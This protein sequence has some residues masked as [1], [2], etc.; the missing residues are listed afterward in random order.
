MTSNWRHSA[1]KFDL[2]CV[3]CKAFLRK[4]NHVTYI[5]PISQNQRNQK[6]QWQE[7]RKKSLM[8]LPSKSC[9]INRPSFSQ[10]NKSSVQLTSHV[11]HNKNSSMFTTV[12]RVAFPFA[13]YKFG[14]FSHFSGSLMNNSIHLSTEIC[15]SIFFLRHEYI[16]EIF[17]I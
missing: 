12:T 3:L 15:H 8:I 16:F 17:W 10:L 14:V 11:F 6:N 1:I 9:I 7:Y 13:R 4:A 2:Y 5:W